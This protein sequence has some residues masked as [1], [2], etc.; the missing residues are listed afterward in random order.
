MEPKQVFQEAGFEERLAEAIQAACIE[1]V[2][3]M[4]IEVPP[5][6]I[7]GAIF[8]LVTLVAWSVFLAFKS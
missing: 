4:T 7:I 3:T 6:L 5:I 2:K 1:S 8:T